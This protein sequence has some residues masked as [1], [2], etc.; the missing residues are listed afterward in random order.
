M[1]HL[2]EDKLMNEVRHFHSLHRQ[3]PPLQHPTQNPNLPIISHN[4]IP[5]SPIFNTNPYSIYPVQHVLN[6]NCVHQPLIFN[7]NPSSVHPIYSIEN[8]NSLK[9]E[10]TEYKFFSKVFAEDSELRFYYEKNCESGEFICRVFVLLVG[11][12]DIQKLPS[13]YLPQT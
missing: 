13:T 4:F 6:P 3:G 1:P 9:D 11:G 8:P 10:C 7:Y 2:T 12:R 5:N